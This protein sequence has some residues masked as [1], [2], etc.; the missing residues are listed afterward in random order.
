MR[1]VAGK[2]AGFQAWIV[3]GARR[4]SRVP[5]VIVKLWPEPEGRKIRLAERIAQTV[6]EVLDCP[7]RS[8]SVSI[9]EVEQR[10]WDEKVVEADIFGGRAKLYR[11]PP[12]SVRR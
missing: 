8:V 5:H 12:G 1:R 6:A 4:R 10:D 11:A 9:E 2:G 3:R 7:E